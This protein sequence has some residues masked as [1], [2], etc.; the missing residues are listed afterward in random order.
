M[1]VT[2]SKER[3]LDSLFGRLFKVSLIVQR[4][5]GHL[6]THTKNQLLKLNAEALKYYS[7]TFTPHIC[8]LRKKSGFFR[9]VGPF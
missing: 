9:R 6:F 3:I 2:F 4:H 1:N 8:L 7:S 5:R